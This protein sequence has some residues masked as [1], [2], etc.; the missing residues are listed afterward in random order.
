MYMYVHVS[1]P[2]LLQYDIEEHALG[3]VLNSC[4]HAES[5]VP[6][7][8]TCICTTCILY[9]HSISLYISHLH[10]CTCIVHTCIYMYIVLYMYTVGTCT[11]TCSL[12]YTVHVHMHVQ[13]MHNT[14]THR[15]DKEIVDTDAE[16]E[17]F[18]DLFVSK[19]LLSSKLLT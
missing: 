6:H 12:H 5:T 4:L 16:E 2:H 9:I 8:H 3:R 19:V 17:R 7:V 11:C 1:M 10:T 13:Y 15:V 18:A 14:F